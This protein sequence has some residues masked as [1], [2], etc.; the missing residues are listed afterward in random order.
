MVRLA[1][2]LFGTVLFA[3]GLMAQ[4]ERPIRGIELHLTQAEQLSLEERVARVNRMAEPSW[5]ALLAEGPLRGF[6]DPAEQ[7]PPPGSGE[8]GA[9]IVTVVIPAGPG[10][11]E[12]DKIELFYYQLPTGYDPFGTPI[13][14]VVAYHGFGLSAASNHNLSDIDEEADARGWIYMSPTGVDDKLFASEMSQ[15]HVDLTFDYMSQNFLVDEERLYMIGFSMG[16]GYVHS[17]AA[18]R[19]DP[20]GRMIAAL[21]TVSAAADWTMVYLTEG[22]QVKNLME[23]PENFG[24]SPQF[25]LDLYQK[26]SA[27]HHDPA[28]YPPI[29]GTLVENRSMAFNNVTTPTYMT[30]DT[31]DRLS[32]IASMNIALNAAL[33]SAGAPVEFVPTS[34]TV[35]GEGA[36][37]PHHWAV[38]DVVDCFDFLEQHSA[39]RYPQDFRALAVESG[40]ISWTKIVQR[41][42]ATVLFTPFEASVDGPSRTLAIEGLDTIAQLELD[43]GLAGL[44]G[45]DPVRVEI[46]I[47]DNS[48]VA[49]TLTGFETRPSYLTEAVGGALVTG[50]DSDPA[51]DSLRLTLSGP[52]SVAFD[53][54]QDSDWTSTLSSTP[55]PVL[56]GG[57]TTLTL[58]GPPSAAV[59]ALIVGLT[60][61][62]Y[63]AKGAKLAVVPIKV[64]FLPLDPQGDLSTPL[65][66]ADDPIL[67]GLRIPLQAVL[68]D[69]SNALQSVSNLWGLHTEAP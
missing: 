15:A 44:S 23:L 48:A 46:E 51:T 65:S 26:A 2:T 68:L 40:Q 33:S 10:G 27:L 18:Q 57:S 63:M 39:D 16:G 22:A 28:S 12:T 1:L 17:Y 24:G 69:G 30:Y 3:S 6:P 56:T 7:A 36:P 59:G 5:E 20:A 37:A 64:L 42:S 31:G 54:I 53:V 34:G 62:L 61:Q 35:D 19:R 21:G 9:S 14:M 50:V 38:L 13:P 4:S 29:P 58:D 52:Q 47:V 66:L 11:T 43:A 60:E 32:Q 8:G 55:D 41:A 45:T 67:A 49:L 25:F